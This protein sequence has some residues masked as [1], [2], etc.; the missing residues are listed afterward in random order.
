MKYYLIL[1]AVNSWGKIKF[2]YLKIT[3]LHGELIYEM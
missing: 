2:E 1:L 3:H